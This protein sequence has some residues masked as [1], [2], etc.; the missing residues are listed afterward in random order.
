MLHKCANPVCSV[1]FRD[2]E[3]GKLFVV[4]TG[5]GQ[6]KPGRERRTRRMQHYW[7]CDE[8]AMLY[9]LVDSTTGIATVPLC[10]KPPFAAKAFDT[11]SGQTGAIGTA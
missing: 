4:E 7:L 6:P 11:T 1:E 10:V 3:R 9:T 8:C 5:S 2:L